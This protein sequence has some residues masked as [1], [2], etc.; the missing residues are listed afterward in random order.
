MKTG[1]DMKRGIIGLAIIAVIG[2]GVM[3]FSEV[4][5]EAISSAQINTA[6]FFVERLTCGACSEKIRQ[7]VMSLDGVASVETDVAKGTSQVAFDPTRTDSVQIAQAM[8]QSGYPAQLSA[9]ETIAGGMAS[10]VDTNLYIAQ[11]GDRFVARTEFNDLVEQQRLQGAEN[12]KPLPVQYMVRFAW[13][14]ILQRELLL[15]AASAA[16]IVV[17]NAELDAYI[18]RKQL[19]TTDR[20]NVKNSLLTERYLNQKQIDRQINST[21]Y[22]QLLNSLQKSVPV[23]IYDV[24][25][26]QNLSG[27]NKKS[28]GCGGGCC[29]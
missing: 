3:V 2:I 27:G 23:Q 1:V 18:E 6:E 20:E 25:L 16:G 4:S 19:T 22:A 24:S 9:R 17:P 7:A 15:N 5:T 12:G 10:D 21:E 11:I 14:T 13:M 28:G 26:N 8:T 29:S